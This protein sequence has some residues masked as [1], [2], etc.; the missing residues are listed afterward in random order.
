[1]DRILDPSKQCGSD[2]VQLDTRASR[3]GCIVMFGM[4]GS[5]EYLEGEMGCDVWNVRREFLFEAFCGKGY[6]W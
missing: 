1:M 4:S 6:F 5:D 2:F 3:V